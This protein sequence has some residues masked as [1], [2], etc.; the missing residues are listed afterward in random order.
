MK[1]L[2][3]ACYRIEPRSLRNSSSVPPTLNAKPGSKRVGFRAFRVSYLLVTYTAAELRVQPMTVVR[4]QLPR[5][6]DQQ[7]GQVKIQPMPFSLRLAFTHSVTVAS[8][9]VDDIASHCASNRLPT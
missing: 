9:S 4:Y 7:F 1:L 5:I 3:S 8:R 6:F 2:L